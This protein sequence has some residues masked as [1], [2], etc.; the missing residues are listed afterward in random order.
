L[1][2]LKSKADVFFEL[3]RQRRELAGALRLNEMFVA[4]LGHDLRNPLATL[5]TGAELLRSQATDPVQDRVL[6]RMTAAAGRMTRMIDQL[7]D[8]TR[9]RLAGGLGFAAARG[10]V[11]VA[12][13]VQRTVDELR[14]AH[15]DRALSLEVA[16]DAA[17]HGDA[18]R[19]LQLFSNLLANA[20]NHG[21]PA[22]PVVVCVAQVA[23]GSEREVV[24]T[25]RNG[26]VIPPD[27]L[28]TLFDPFRGR[29][30]ASGKARGLGL[31]LYISKQIADSHGARIEVTSSS[32]RGETTFA[33]HLP[34]VQAPCVH[35]PSGRPSAE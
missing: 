6:Q 31:G 30:S 23:A 28:P 21:S 5:V 15:P 14:G 22:A 8:L 2:I 32:E 34:C 13:L 11:D 26:G 19:L 1:C 33:V 29:E 27:L 25:V 17:I 4:I 3:Y 18:D 20:L 35:A 9:A 7:L 16:G 24:V 12:S 10:P